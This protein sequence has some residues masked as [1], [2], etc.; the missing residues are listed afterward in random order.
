M[1]VIRGVWRLSL[2]MVALPPGIEMKCTLHSLLAAVI[3][4]A[5]TNR[6]KNAFNLR[7]RTVDILVADHRITLSVDQAL[8]SMAQ[9]THQG[10][11]SC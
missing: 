11:L 8:P 1:P 10:H 7:R 9:P 5:G 4:M 2:A 6:S 3:G